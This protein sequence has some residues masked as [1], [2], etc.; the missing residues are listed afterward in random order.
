M[1][2]FDQTDTASGKIFYRDACIAEI[3]NLRMG[4]IRFRLKGEISIGMNVPVNLFWQQYINH[5]NP[6]RNAGSHAR[7]EHVEAG[8]ILKFKCVGSNA[9]DALE[10]VYYANVSLRDSE[11][12]I[13]DIDASLRIRPGC[14][15]FIEPNPHHGE[16]EFCQV[17]PYQT[18]PI[19]S[20]EQ[21]RYDACLIRRNDIW[22]RI[23]HHHIESSDK[24]N[25]IL[26]SGDQFC[27]II[28]DE[29]PVV[30]ILSR[31]QVYAGLCAYM[32]D[33]HFGYRAPLNGVLKEDDSFTARF[34]LYSIDR[35]EASLKSW[36]SQETYPQ[37]IGNTPIVQAGVNTF[38]DTLITTRIPWR[39][40]WPWTYEVKGAAECCR[41]ISVGYDDSASLRI[42]L[43]GGEARWM[44]TTF[45]S[46]FGFAPLP[47]NTHYRL[48]AWIKTHD[49][50]G[51]VRLLIRIHRKDIGDVFDVETYEVFSSIPIE[52]SLEDWTMV[53]VETPS[54][55]PVPDRLHIILSMEGV[56][57]VWF[58]NV[59]LNMVK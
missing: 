32:W 42:T 58:D 43:S 10:S 3:E 9:S 44:A 36:M 15:W 27:W 54:I 26:N 6:E 23:P 29:N 12:I 18:F 45:G 56:G 37:E 52:S 41:D 17:W 38:S 59:S 8:H 30:E 7:I 55:H 22:Q 33:G 28:E 49:I 53:T 16:L 11:N 4:N 5:Q 39:H 2:R 51:T 31:N 57:T 20:R 21:K 48:S 40:V 14:E 46:A 13:Y 25:I 47:D 24:H 19:D 34:R 50:R 35:V 1:F